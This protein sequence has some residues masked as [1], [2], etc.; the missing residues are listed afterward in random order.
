[1]TT[2]RA[3]TSSQG[4]F[5]LSGVGPSALDDAKHDAAALERAVEARAEE[6]FEA[7]KE[8]AA[9]RAEV[10]ASAVETLARELH[11]KDEGWLG[12]R[13]EALAATVRRTG[14]NVQER[15]IDELTEDVRGWSKNPAVF[16][17]GAFALGLLAGRF[18]KSS[19]GQTQPRQQVA[20]Q[21]VG[22]PPFGERPFVDPPFGESSSEAML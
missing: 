2:E 16:L 18:L 6:K 3:G 9:G 13:A 12:D 17:G 10:V 8:K 22:E 15:H 5:A 4:R 14:Q 11:D 19:A 21:Q 1:M 20:L 7:V